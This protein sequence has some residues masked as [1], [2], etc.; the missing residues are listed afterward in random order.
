MVHGLPDARRAC[1]AGR[2]LTLLSAQG[3][4][5][6]AGCGWW[7]AIAETIAAEH[8]KLV[9]AD[10]L[11]CGE[12]P[13]WALAAIRIGQRGLILAPFAPGFAAVAAIAADRS[14]LLLTGRPPALDMAA[15]GADRRLAEWLPARP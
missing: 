12:A 14:L 3:A 9:V 1:A 8:P 13:G 7:R 5:G 11:D 10:I 2:P 4:A 15:R 6:Y